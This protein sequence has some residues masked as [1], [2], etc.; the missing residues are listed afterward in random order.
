MW[1]NPNKAKD[2][3]LARDIPLN[4]ENVKKEFP[5][6]SEH[7]AQKENVVENFSSTQVKKTCKEE[8]K[9]SSNTSCST[10]E[11]GIS[12]DESRTVRF[13]NNLFV[14]SNYLHNVM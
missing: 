5:Q 1:H 9:Q 3:N 11:I 7:V 4:R 14:V 6:D 8:Y 13:R 2:G 10:D 12:I